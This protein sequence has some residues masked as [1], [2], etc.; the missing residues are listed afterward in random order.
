MKFTTPF[1]MPA[2]WQASTMRQALSGATDA[3]FTMTVLP[4]INAGAIFQAG[5][6]LG[7]F[8]GVTSPTTPMGLRMANM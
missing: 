4:Q 3:G 1:G 8:H 7:K 6:A 5:M 2:W